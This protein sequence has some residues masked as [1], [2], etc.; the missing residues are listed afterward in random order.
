MSQRDAASIPV[1]Y[2]TAYYALVHRARLSKHQSILIHSGAGGVGQAAIAL[3]LSLGCEV[4]TTV[5]TQTKVEYLL[6]RFPALR[7]DHIGHSRSVSSSVTYN[8]YA[9]VTC[10]LL[11]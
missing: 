7:E 10:D 1:V 6:K 9:G 3:A 4:Y 11:A 8:L 5:G 2:A